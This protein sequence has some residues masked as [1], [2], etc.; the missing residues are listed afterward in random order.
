M[1]APRPILA[2]RTYLLSRR[3][4]Q[5]QFLLRPDPH[6]ENVFLYC[7]GE[8]AAR[9]D[10][11]LHAWIALSN[12]A[13]LMVRDNHGNLPEFLAHLHRM[14][15]RALNAY[16]GRWE[17]FWAAEQPSTVYLVEAGDRFDKL[18]YLLA[19]P[20]ADHLVDRVSDWPGACSLP[21]HLSGRPKTVKRPWAFFRKGGRMPE[22]VTLRAERPEGF[23]QLGEQEWIEKLTAA[24]C[25]A[26]Q[27]ARDERAKGQ[28]RVLGRKAVLRVAPTDRPRSLEPRGRLSPQVACKNRKNRIDVLAALVRFRV[29]HREARMLW[30]AGERQVLFPA[31]TYR[32]LAFGV[33]C[34]AHA[35]ARS[36][37]A[38]S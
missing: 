5:R 35:D 1:T 21:Q 23:E 12:H 30:C 29:A 22:Q 24:V 17:N 32:M 20:V 36:I 15:A 38:P 26:E 4:T 31:G 8:A 19:N 25:A 6:V 10:V 3:C 28:R 18:V 37:A 34:A 14:I 7:L 2:G 13:H 27:K 16:R 33:L 11:T 9:Y